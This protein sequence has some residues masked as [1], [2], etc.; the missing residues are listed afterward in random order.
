MNDLRRILNSQSGQILQASIAAIVT[1]GATLVAVNVNREQKKNQ[2]R[3]QVVVKTIEIEQKLKNAIR[4]DLG[5]QNTVNNN[6]TLACLRNNNAANCAGT[7][8]TAL[9]LVYDETGATTLIDSATQGY[10]LAGTKCTNF[11]AAPADGNADCPYGVSVRWQAITR[12]TNIPDRS[13][14]TTLPTLPTCAA[15][16]CDV[17]IVVQFQINSDKSDLGL[18]LNDANYYVDFSRQESANQEE[19]VVIQQEASNVDAGRFDAANDW[20]DRTL[21]VEVT[22]T[23]GNVAI[24]GDDVNVQ[25]QPGTY[26]CEVTAPVGMTFRHQAA[27]NV[28]GTRYPGTSAYYFTPSVVKQ[29]FTIAVATNVK[30]EHLSQNILGASRDEE[31]GKAV[32]GQV[33]TY[34][35]L[36]CTKEVQ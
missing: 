16:P 32:T 26:S 31:M 24:Q 14:Q 35:V 36:K 11:V 33:N 13:G 34:T 5:W 8:L 9:A 23:G 25:F 21:N 12:G 4:S 10:T 27:L 3:N 30:V 6:A 1:I 22:D 28:G 20:T 17:R 15:D 7:G 18:S 19:I 29:S 2:L